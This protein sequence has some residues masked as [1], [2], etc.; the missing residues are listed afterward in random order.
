LGNL[1]RTFPG[2]SLVEALE[3][4]S[5]LLSKLSKRRQHAVRLLKFQACKY[6]SATSFTAWSNSWGGCWNDQR[7]DVHW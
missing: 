2:Q 1:S 4:F 7:R 3:G 5:S 6:G